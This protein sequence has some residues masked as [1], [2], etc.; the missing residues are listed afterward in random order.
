MSAS[1]AQDATFNMGQTVAEMT[2]N[3][4]TLTFAGGSIDDV[5]TEKGFTTLSTKTENGVKTSA[6][7][8][9][10]GKPVR[11]IKITFADEE[12]TYNLNWGG[13]WNE[14]E[15]INANNSASGKGTL[16]LVS[17]NC[18]PY[19]KIINDIGAGT[20]S[21]PIKKVEVY[22]KQ[23]GFCDDVNAHT[24]ANATKIVSGI[25]CENNTIPLDK[26]NVIGQYCSFSPENGCGIMM[27]A[28]GDHYLSIKFKD[29]ID[30]HELTGFT[31]EG[32]NV[33]SVVDHI[34]FR[35]DDNGATK[36]FGKWTNP[37]SISSFDEEQ[38]TNLKTTNEIRIYNGSKEG[39]F[40]INSIKLT[41]GGSHARAIPTLDASTTQPEM[42]ITE[43]ESLTLKITDDN[44]YWREYSNADHT[45][46]VDTR[47]LT[48]Q[49]I[50]YA[51]FDGS[52]EYGHYAKLKEGH[53][54][55]GIKDGGG[56]DFGI[57][58]TSQEVFVHV[59]VNSSTS[60]TL[61]GL[62]EQTIAL[63]ETLTLSATIENAEYPVLDLYSDPEL[64]QRIGFVDWTT[65]YVFNPAEGVKKGDAG[66][67]KPTLKSGAGVY[68]FAYGAK[69]K[70]NTGFVTPEVYKIT[71]VDRT[72]TVAADF[73]DRGTGGNVA[74]TTDGTLT[75][76]G[77]N[78]NWANIFV[79]PSSTNTNK[80]VEI[81][82]DN[83]AGVT[84]TTRGDASRI[85]IY[86]NEENGANKQINIP[87]SESNVEHKYFWSDFG[88]SNTEV[89]NIRTIAIAGTAADQTIYFSNAKLINLPVGVPNGYRAIHVTHDGQTKERE[90]I[91]HA[92]TGAAGAVPVL[93]SLHGT[94]NDFTGG[95][96][97]NY[98]DLADNEKFIVVYPRG[99]DTR[100]PTWEG[101]HRGWLATGQYNEDVKFFEDIIEWL[102][103]NYLIDRDRVYMTGFSNGGMMTYSTAFTSDCFAGF[104]AVSGYP[105][106]EYHLQ[107]YGNGKWQGSHPVP[108]MHIHGKSDG[109]VKY[110]DIQPIVDN[111]VYR[112]GC[113]FIPNVTNIAA[114]S[115]DGG[116]KN[117][118]AATKNVFGSSTNCPFVYYEVEGMGHEPFCYI[119]E[120]N[121]TPDWD[122]AS[123]TII[124]NFLKDKKRI[125]M[126]DYN[127]RN[128]TE[129]MPRLEDA[130]DFH[131]GHGW[132]QDLGNNILWQYGEQPGECS[133]SGNTNK[134]VYHTIQL[135][136]GFH[137]FKFK[138][139][140][141]MA[142]TSTMWVTVCVEKLAKLGASGNSSTVT[143][144][145]PV[146]KVY[147]KDYNIG[148]VSF[149]INQEESEICE[150]RL[151]FEWHNSDGSDRG[152]EAG[153]GIQISGVSI[154]NSTGVDMGVL[155]SETPKHDFGGYFDFENRLIAQWNFDLCDGA[156]FNRQSLGS[157]WQA[158]D[159]SIQN[160]VITYTYNADLKG[161]QLTY[162]N[163]A[164]TIIPISAG[165]KFKADAGKVK[166]QAYV[167]NGNL[168]RSQLVLEPGV[169]MYVPYVHNSYRN[170][171][172]NNGSATAKTK[173][174]DQFRDYMDCLHHIN[175]DI[176]YVSSSPD[177]F[178]AIENEHYY[179]GNNGRP[180]YENDDK[181]NTQND[182]L[183]IS[184]GA[185]ERVKGAKVSLPEWEKLNYCGKQG[186][187]CWVTIKNQVT[188]DRLAV[189]RNLVTSFY[190]E[191]ISIDTDQSRPYPGMRYIGSPQGN[192]V[193][194][195]QTF[196][197][198]DKAIAMTFG[199]WEYN[200]NE[201]KDGSGGKVTDS[202]SELNVY[203][204]EGQGEGNQD[205]NI[206]EIDVTKVPLATD[207][208]PV[209]S[210]NANRAYSETV[211]PVAV[212]WNFTNRGLSYHDKN[213]GDFYLSIGD[214]G[215]YKYVENLTPWSLPCRGGYIKF[216]PTYPG[217]LNVHILQ[218]AGQVYY[219]ADEFGKLVKD[220]F[221][222]TG[223]EQTVSGINGVGTAG[224]Y[225][226]DQKDNV[227]YVFD[228]YPGKSYYI[229]SNTAAGMGFTG[230]YFEP[231]VYRKYNTLADAQS[232]GLTGDKAK[233][234]YELGRQDIGIK[235]AELN[236]TDGYTGPSSL[237]FTEEVDW[238][239]N[240]TAS[241]SAEAAKEKTE[242]KKTENAAYVTKYGSEPYYQS[243]QYSN[244][245]VH[246]RY[247]RSFE[248]NVWST[249]C[250]PYSLNHL[251]LQDIFGDDVKVILM[252]DVQEY[253]RNGYDVTTANFIYHQNQ[254]IIAGY[255]Y[256]IYPSKK[257]WSVTANVMVYDEGQTPS[258]VS[259]NS[260]GQNTVTHP[261]NED[262]KIAA[263][264]NYDGIKCYDFMGN[265]TKEQLPKGSYV[266][267]TDGKLTRLPQN[268]EAKPFRAFLKYNQE[269]D[270]GFM[271]KERM[272]EAVNY[273]I[274]ID[275]EE[276]TTI[277]DLLLQS[278][279]VGSKTNVYSINGTMVRQNTDDLRGLPKG[280]YIVNGKKYLVK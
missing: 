208:F 142:N 236:A 269:V 217:V 246:V 279:I 268:Q 4:C 238:Y 229:F 198:Y 116:P 265:F 253:G 44:G 76:T 103:K 39:S 187:D 192:K 29:V 55:F 211:N 15:T 86:Y 242:I 194:D 239:S 134:N 172:G 196:T 158:D 274:D 112:N 200:Y 27:N 144:F 17:N 63:G 191:N 99:L 213:N 154:L 153:K 157:D 252:R 133:H 111:M 53:Y 231:Y 70:G 16:V 131:I 25:T 77:A 223:T 22:Y 129:F 123:Q 278:G 167:E 85:I 78:D 91:V 2:E 218:E 1:W 18:P 64:T 256:L 38:K 10:T 267:A 75:T 93:F 87:A 33:S 71:V 250:L 48:S 12:T 155:H 11:Y 183:F 210:R 49:Y 105:M 235:T 56:C 244:K 145:D 141:S 60:V 94:N 20:E 257:A 275:G 117:T 203:H 150:Y 69:K 276:T 248:P 152:I 136:Q 36:E 82:A 62:A 171:K 119:S 232:A 37:T 263:A 143:P 50:P 222:K 7:M 13:A 89:K 68:Y 215:N 137:N 114:T 273:G 54:Y 228:V 249:I 28:S 261:G 233:E 101:N 270:G 163:S 264:F 61:D 164:N 88:L 47:I 31:I 170:D 109:F 40:K 115:G 79:F 51:Y 216:E 24:E 224:H 74:L 122:D 127:G 26:V 251:Q 46:E 59:K 21:T 57:Y 181:I 160:G 230:F 175:R 35:Y 277:E 182:F 237:S 9:L 118:K 95:G 280:M 219:I 199:G 147:E 184:G 92:P 243:I 220:V 72:A 126:S 5:N 8:T 227:K 193:A 121:D 214:G 240:Q 104:A 258:L 80:N 45:G 42:V 206:G 173:N 6:S 188:I 195:A 271:A 19:I 148:E 165:L 23:A 14:N 166:V 272:I 41:F 132:K 209:Y 90:F 146:V 97:A 113:S 140:S 32:D 161:E 241:L 66:D 125:N 73:T 106:N 178:D 149:N 225:K 260:I 81:S 52:S 100:F 226:I 207:G 266:I 43:G 156:R 245:A 151:T 201:F 221:V 128:R 30:L 139:S 96:V 58:H 197:T 169:Q 176:L 110:A 120:N 189:N 177:F 234:A 174:D 3:G 67:P 204:G 205:Y 107:H 168:V 185:G 162:G 247:G 202:W 254:D 212:D 98:D 102:N 180:K 179:D 108:F 259:I 138:S 65:S 255:P 83:Y 130:P 190:T 84:L 186:D 159:A 124:W 135:G 34:G 262:Y